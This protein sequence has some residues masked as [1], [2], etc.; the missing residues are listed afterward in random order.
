M[1]QSKPLVGEFCRQNPRNVQHEKYYYRLCTKGEQ[2]TSSVTAVLGLLRLSSVFRCCPEERATAEE[3]GLTV[4]TL[5]RCSSCNCF[6]VSCSCLTSPDLSSTLA[7]GGVGGSGWTEEEGVQVYKECR[8]I[9][10]RIS[11]AM[12]CRQWTG[13]RGR[14]HL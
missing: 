9:S 4:S 6:T 3:L 8:N 11:H 5:F 7:W 13:G 12:W 2:L 10:I 14:G 1:A